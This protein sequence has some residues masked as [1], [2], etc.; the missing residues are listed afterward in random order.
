MTIKSA[1]EL[2]LSLAQ[3]ARAAG[4]TQARIAAAIGT[5]Q[6]QVS[7]ILSGKSRRESRLLR[8]I[9][10]FVEMHA[11]AQVSLERVWSSEKLA[12]A[13]ATAW[14]GTQA[15]EE[16]IATVIRSLVLFRGNPSIDRDRK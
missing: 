14:D 3:R 16:A 10:A 4:L 15:S 8:E 5:S 1:G 9:S 2:G 13:L 11:P 7:R 6:P 12:R